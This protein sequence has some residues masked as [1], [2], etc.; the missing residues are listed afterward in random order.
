MN[1]KYLLNKL[2]IMN[3]VKL[4]LRLFNCKKFINYGLHICIERPDER[5]FR[6]NVLLLHFTHVHN[7]FGLSASALVHS[8]VHLFMTIA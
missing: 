1:G 4:F 8:Y 7:M 6:I 3:T 2:D 5:L